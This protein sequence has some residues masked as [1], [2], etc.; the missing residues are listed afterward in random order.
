VTAA[1]ST[2]SVVFVPFF[3]SLPAEPLCLASVI[4]VP[5]LN[6]TPS[7]VPDTRIFV[8][9]FSPV[10]FFTSVTQSNGSRVYCSPAPFFPECDDLLAFAFSVV[11]V[12]EKLGFRQ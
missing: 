2:F 7:L 12:Q 5:R 3:L 8:V 1:V 11:F 9:G 4:A 10:L 6:L